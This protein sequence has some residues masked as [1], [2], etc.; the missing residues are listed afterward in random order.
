MSY[1][2]A[3]NSFLFAI[4]NFEVTTY[5]TAPKELT[6]R[7]PKV[8]MGRCISSSKSGQLRVKREERV[9]G[10]LNALKT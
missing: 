3:P 4:Q 5:T 1:L 9:L 2:R 8:P 10:T 6:Q 7:L